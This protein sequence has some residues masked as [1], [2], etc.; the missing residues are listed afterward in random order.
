MAKTPKT[1][2]VPVEPTDEMIV[3]A[4]SKIGG[5]S[6]FDADDRQEIA[7]DIWSAMLAA[8]PEALANRDPQAGGAVGAAEREVGRA[9][10]E[11][12]ETIMDAEEGSPEF[13]ELFYLSH[14]AESVEEVGG[15]D[16]P[17]QRPMTLRE[18]VEEIRAVETSASPQDDPMGGDATDDAVVAHMVQR[19]LGWKLPEDFSPDN[20][21][22]FKATFNDHMDPPMR[23]NPVGTNL[24]DARQAE[25]MVRHMLEG[26]PK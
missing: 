11:R 23:R 3:T 7:R 22:S 6:T 10:Y 26:L 24:F 2:F 18:I 9:V 16:G 21:I 17:I 19:F 20:G 14:L 1:A 25:A 8:A 4:M 5:G 15:Y 12:I 13:E